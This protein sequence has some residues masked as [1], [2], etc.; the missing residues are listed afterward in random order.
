MKTLLA[1]SFLACTVLQSMGQDVTALLRKAEQA[2]TQHASTM[3]MAI[4][5]VKP[6]YTKVINMR[7]WSIGNKHSLAVI[8]SPKRDS[9]LTYMRAGDDLYMYSPR[10]DRV[11]KLPSSMLMQGWMGTDAQFDN[12]LGQSSFVDDFHHDY[13][14]KVD[15]NGAPCHLIACTPKD[16]V[17]VAHA[18]VNVYV[19]VQHGGWVRMQFFNRR[20]QV[21]QQMD[22]LRYGVMDGVLMPVEIGMTG[23]DGVQRTTMEVL[24]WRK[25]PDLTEAYFVPSR[26]TQLEP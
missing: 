26:M 15:V 20:D 19:S 1:F 4:T 5:N 7:T 10:I 6:R 17:A 3:D 18:R 13:Q 12:V 8:T 21:S 9:G 16:D 24:Q 25:R 14:G 11:S 22:A 23:K 2:S